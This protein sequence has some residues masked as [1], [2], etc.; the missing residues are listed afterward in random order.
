MSKGEDE[1]G[2]LLRRLFNNRAIKRQHPIKMGNRTLRVDYY[3]PGIGLA[4]EYDGEQHERYSNF[5]HRTLKAFRNSKE[6]DSFKADALLDQ[7]IEL[8]RFRAGEPINE[9]VLLAKISET[10]S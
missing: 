1:L 4:F 8:I 7:G 6:R 9:E 2:R 10:Y 3:I 5:F